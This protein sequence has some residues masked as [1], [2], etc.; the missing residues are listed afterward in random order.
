[1]GV[2]RIAPA[3]ALL[4]LAA[5]LTACGVRNT[6]DPVAAA[7]TKTEKAGGAKMSMSI[8]ISDGASQSFTVK[9]DGVFD[10][11]EG[12]MTMDMSSALESAGL[13]AGSGS[14]IKLLYLKEDGDPVMYMD[15]PFLSSQLP[16]GKSWIRIDLQKVGQELGLDL[17]RL[18]GQ[19]N[20]NPAQALDMLRASGQVDEVG[21]ATIDGASTTEYKGAIDLAKAA[22]LDGGNAES[23]VNG[24]I[25]Q[26]A[27]S[28]I[29]ID[30]WIGDDGL[31][32]R[33]IMNEDITKD[34]HTVSTAVTLDLSDFG[35][36]V[37]VTAPPA[38]QVFDAT[39]LA[40]QMSQGGSSALVPKA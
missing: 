21:P 28:Q 23:M 36:Q 29:P 15:F 22:K 1:M 27:P 14:G 13:P 33:M 24:L 32:R 5:S 39:A 37:S 9:A 34:G 18:M 35:T 8:A 17:G 11:N 16:G 19:S 3:L 26:G 2:K 4:G 7:A 12:E 40:G 31:V 30:V 10:Q 6:V 20:Q 25:A 38:D